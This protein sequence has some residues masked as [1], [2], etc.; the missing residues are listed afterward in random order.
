[1]RAAR[2][3]LPRYPVQNP[4]TSP[5]RPRRYRVAASRLQRKCR[6]AVRHRRA[7][8]RRH[9]KAA[10]QSK[11]PLPAQRNI[12]AAGCVL[13]RRHQRRNL[14]ASFRSADASWLRSAACCF[15][16]SARPRVLE[17]AMRLPLR[18][19]PGLLS[20]GTTPHAP[21]ITTAARG[22][23][24]LKRTLMPASNRPL[25][26]SAPPVLTAKPSRRSPPRPSRRQHS[27]SVRRASPASRSVRPDHVA[28]PAVHPAGHKSSKAARP[29]RAGRRPPSAYRP[30]IAAFSS[31][32]RSKRSAPFC[33]LV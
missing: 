16:A 17:G 33:F 12:T 32:N 11:K 30:L 6:L 1:M 10:A 21:V 3:T 20:R 22:C 25:K 31:Y 5:A 28:V 7:H 23:L 29:T 9:H 2:S 8:F 4:L 26:R 19:A 13:Q 14:P 18:Y 24:P 15:L 27:V